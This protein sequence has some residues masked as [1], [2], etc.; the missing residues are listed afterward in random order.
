VPASSH[1][2]GL[3]VRAEGIVLP[4]GPESEPLSWAVHGGQRA[5]VLGP[6]GS[7]KTT[8]LRVLSGELGPAAGTVTREPG[9]VVAHLPQ[10]PPRPGPGESV[11]AFVQQ[12]WPGPGEPLREALGKVL[13]ADPARLD[14]ARVSEGELRRAACAAVFQAAPDL[15]LLDEP[16]NH[17]DLATIELLERALDEFTGAVV[18][19]YHDG[20]FLRRLHP[21]GGVR[22]IEGRWEHLCWDPSPPISL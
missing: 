4:A 7:G 16:T 2:S 3:L 9:A 15:L 18:A 19:A 1:R 6:S 10:T 12:H 14:A 11:L 8:L 5:A 20:R 17:L 21:A 13:F 22:G